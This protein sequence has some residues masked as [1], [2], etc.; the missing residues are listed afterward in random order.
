MRQRISPERLG[1]YV[2]ASGGD[3]SEALNLY[4]WNAEMTAAL[5]TTIGH[6]EIV[7]RN[8][9]H[10]NLKAWSTRCFAEPRWYLDVGHVLQSRATDDV[11]IA[12]RRVVRDGSRA[13]TAGLVVAEL[14]LGF[15]RYLLA[16]HY[17][18]TLWRTTLHEV[19][20]GRSRRVVRDAVE[21][22]HLSRN[23]MA[24]HEP[25]FN[26]P[27]ADIHATA[28]ELVGWICPVSRAWIER[29]CRTA[30]TLRAKP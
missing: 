26:R 9:V 4:V 13:E 30:E 15:W 23:R 21:V 8:A 20:P 24:H 22:L 16:N 12:R 2:A 19:F 25:M 1:P 10:E 29:H 3:I 18:R 27:I 17:D 5:A 14:S 7:L 6:V 11:R 28:M